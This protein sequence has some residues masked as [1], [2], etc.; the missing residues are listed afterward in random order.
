MD[1]KQKAVT[2]GEKCLFV[3]SQHFM[4]QWMLPTACRISYWFVFLLTGLL[5][6][7]LTITEWHSVDGQCMQDMLP[8]HCAQYVTGSDG[9]TPALRIQCLR[10]HREFAW[11]VVAEDLCTQC[12][13]GLHCENFLSTHSR[14]AQSCQPVF[15]L[16]LPHILR[17]S[18]QVNVLNIISWCHRLCWGSLGWCHQGS[19]IQH[20]LMA[21]S[22]CK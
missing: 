13:E 14:S 9:Y 21:L 3:W 8:G 16:I 6:V 2:P 4:I 17:K 20:S 15:I 22:T 12:L 7:W 18:M 19:T 5:C 11:V 10:V 1:I